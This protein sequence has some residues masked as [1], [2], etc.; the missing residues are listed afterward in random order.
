MHAV[1]AGR[2]N[3][4]SVVG[5]LTNLDIERDFAQKSN[6]ARVGL[7]TCAAMSEYH[8][9]AKPLH[10]LQLA[11]LHQPRLAAQTEQFRLRRSIDV[12]VEDAGLE[13]D[14]GEAQCEITG[15]GGFADAAFAGGHR[16][17]VLDAGNAGRVRG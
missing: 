1:W 4:P 12:G 7:M 2:D 9:D 16:D 6:A 17:D 5:R 10:R 13:S 15:R 14:G 3:R 8:L 11:P